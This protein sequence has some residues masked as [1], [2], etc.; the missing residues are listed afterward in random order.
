MPRQVADLR[1][2]SGTYLGTANASQADAKIRISP[3]QPPV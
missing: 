3:P 1:A 2:C